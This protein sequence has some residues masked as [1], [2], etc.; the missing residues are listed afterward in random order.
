MFFV[1]SFLLEVLLE[2]LRTSKLQVLSYRVPMSFAA[3]DGQGP[4]RGCRMPNNLNL[5]RLRHFYTA[6]PCN[7]QPFLLANGHFLGIIIDHSP[8]SL[9]ACGAS[10]LV[11][12]LRIDLLLP[13]WPSRQAPS[14]STRAKKRFLVET[15]QH[16]HDAAFPNSNKDPLAASARDLS[17]SQG[18]M[19]MGSDMLVR[20][21]LLDPFHP[22][23]TGSP[24]GC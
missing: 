7:T 18:R 17:W 12:S 8:T 2:G 21:L 9:V 10:L 19:T 3:T 11:L 13:G 1:I 5:Q 20:T 16:D 4:S 24:S 6:S 23:P 14:K 15:S 22:S